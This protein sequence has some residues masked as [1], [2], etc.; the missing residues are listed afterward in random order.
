MVYIICTSQEDLLASLL[1]PD[2]SCLSQL[3][4]PLSSPPFQTSSDP[5]LP[6]LDTVTDNR[7]VSPALSFSSGS[8]VGNSPATSSPPGDV[9]MMSSSMANDELSV[10][11]GSVTS[12]SSGESSS[13]VRIDL[14]M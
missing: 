14:G 6:P 5:T 7:T 4:P 9:M 11:L 3:P 2:S 13:D 8:P 1:E 12:I 10:L